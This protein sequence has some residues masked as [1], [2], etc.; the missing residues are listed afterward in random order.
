MQNIRKTKKRKTIEV[1]PNIEQLAQEKLL[2]ISI[3]ADDRY[4]DESKLFAIE[5]RVVS[6]P[7]STEMRM[8]Q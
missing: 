3:L 1:H 6:E 2:E 4:E 5:D 7:V 8:S